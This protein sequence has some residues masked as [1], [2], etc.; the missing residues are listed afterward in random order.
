MN[1]IKRDEKSNAVK[2]KQCITFN[3]VS[4]ILGKRGYSA[5]WQACYFGYS[6]KSTKKG[7]HCYKMINAL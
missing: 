7:F 1:V 4:R 5:V 2:C 6:R 3:Y